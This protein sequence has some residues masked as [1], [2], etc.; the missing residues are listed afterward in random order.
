MGLLSTIDAP[1]GFRHRA[2]Y[3]RHIAPNDRPFNDPAQL[4]PNTPLNAAPLGFPASPEELAH[5]PDGSLPPGLLP[6]FG[7][8]W[9]CPRRAPNR[10]RC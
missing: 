3:P 2:P 7:P 10:V 6:F 5:N 9:G 8:C 1:G 4:K